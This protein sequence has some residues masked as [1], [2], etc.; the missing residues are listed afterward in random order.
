MG[1]GDIKLLAMMGAFLGAKEI[2]FVFFFAPILALP[3]ALYMKLF[4]KAETIPY[5]PFL[6]MTGAIFYFFGDSIT[7]YFL[8]PYGV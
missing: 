7:H 2:L 8:E 3:F 4:K 1:G 6:A 5:G